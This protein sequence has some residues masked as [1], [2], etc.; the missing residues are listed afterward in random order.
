[1]YFSKEL[2]FSLSHSLTEAIKSICA[3][4][5]EDRR[6]WP[7]RGVG[8]PRWYLGS[9]A[10]TAARKALIYTNS[11]EFI[12]A[13]S[14]ATRIRVSTS[15][16]SVCTNSEPGVFILVVVLLWLCNRSATFSRSHLTSQRGNG[17]ELVW[18]PGCEQQRNTCN[19]LWD[20]SCW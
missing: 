16:C 11:F 4:A 1:M 18:A 17:F 19:V 7:H 6:A 13:L 3:V 12:I 14:P 8:A 2:A 15:I 9:N 20:T 10:P 5:L